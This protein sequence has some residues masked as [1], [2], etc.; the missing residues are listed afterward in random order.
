MFNIYIYIYIYIHTHF[1]NNNLHKDLKSPIC[2]SGWRALAN[3]S[4]SVSDQPPS[5]TQCA[6]PWLKYYFCFHR[7]QLWSVPCGWGREQICPT[8]TQTHRYPWHRVFIS[9][10]SALMAAGVFL[11]QSMAS[12]HSKL[13][14]P[15]HSTVDTLTN[16]SQAPQASG[17]LLSTPPVS[18]PLLAFGK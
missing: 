14:L 13:S 17:L 16:L 9:P 4:L 2:N 6:K 1:L 15:P 11:W 3:E 18:S 10:A 8:H 5:G 12:G 7:N